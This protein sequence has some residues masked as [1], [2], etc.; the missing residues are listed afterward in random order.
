MA[1]LLFHSFK[2]KS[3][4]LPCNRSFSSL[5]ADELNLP[6][7]LAWGDCNGG[8]VNIGPL[9]TLRSGPWHDHD[10]P[11]VGLTKRGLMLWLLFLSW[12]WHLLKSCV[13]RHFDGFF[14]IS[15]K[16]QKIN[17]LL[18]PSNLHFYESSFKS[19]IVIALHNIL[20]F[21][22]DFF[23]NFQLFLLKSLNQLNKTINK[24]CSTGWPCHRLFFHR[25]LLGLESH[26]SIWKHV[27]MNS[28]GNKFLLLL[29]I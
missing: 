14:T 2:K 6:T 9:S 4:W 13:E 22:Y 28:A 8:H 26:P 21:W 15:E 24:R 18:V 19:N 12:Y 17:D 29:E 1:L 10:R 7:V 3:S 23:P 5:S 11:R 27:N 20:Q 16:C 25:D